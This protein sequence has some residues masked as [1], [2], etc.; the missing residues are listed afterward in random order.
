MTQTLNVGGVDVTSRVRFEDGIQSLSA[1]ADGTFADSA[2]R[3]DDPLGELTFLQLQLVTSDESAC[4]PTRCFTGYL[5]SATI[6]RGVYRNGPGRVWELEVADLN[7]LLQ[8]RVFH[9]ADAKRPAET[10]TTRVTWLLS[11][12]GLAGLV[13]DNGLVMTNPSNFGEADYRGQYANDV[14]Q[15]ICAASGGLNPIFFVYW[16]HSAGQA[17]LFYNLPTAA[18][19]D[20]TLR[21]SNVLS[22]VDEI[23]TFWGYESAQLQQAGEDI[24]DGVYFSYVGGTIYRQLASTYTTFGIH[25]DAA[26]TTDRIQSSTTASNHADIFLANHSGAID[27]IGMTVRLPRNKVNLIEAGMRLAFREEHLP[28]YEGAGFTYSRIAARTLTFTQ[29]TNE[30][31]DVPLE[32]S[33]R[34]I[35]QAGGGD[36]GDFPAPA[37]CTGPPTVAN[38]EVTGLSTLTSTWSFTPTAENLLI[39]FW[40]NRDGGVLAAPS[41]WTRLA[42]LFTGSSPSTDGMGVFVRDSDGTETSATWPSGGPGPNVGNNGEIYI[43]EFAGGSVAGISN[44]QSLTAADSATT[45]TIGSIAPTTGIPTLLLTLFD[46]GNAIRLYTSADTIERQRNS[47]FHPDYII[48]TRGVTSPT[49]TYS[50]SASQNGG[51]WGIDNWGAIA[52]AISCATSAIPPSTAQ[53]FYDIVPIPAPDGATYTFTLPAGYEF[54]DGSLIVKV[55]RLDQTAAVTSYDGAARTFTLSFAPWGTDIIEVTGQGR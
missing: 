10:A 47:S 12:V 1:R 9:A 48:T 26:F 7:F 42:A 50:M 8:L 5:H 3:I 44:L 45:M 17:S 54:A 36:P 14:L 46:R 52:L 2:I 32:L 19:H 20:S 55:D 30:F 21:I 51:A 4:T 31:Y 6:D 38:K 27:T 35:S 13:Y 40:L 24:Y 37:V 33:T 23:T 41:G 39:L 22:D 28:G 18:V 16:D 11:S 29:G 25:R 43:M 49:G 53:W 15:D 34:G